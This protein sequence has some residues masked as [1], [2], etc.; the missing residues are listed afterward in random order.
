MTLSFSRMTLLHGVSSVVR[1]ATMLVLLMT[2]N[3]KGQEWS[4]L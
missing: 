1:T 4:G 3:C 2:G